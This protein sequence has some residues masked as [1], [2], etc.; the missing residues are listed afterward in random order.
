MSLF[1]NRNVIKHPLR[2][3]GC[4]NHGENAG[5]RLCGRRLMYLPEVANPEH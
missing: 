3:L 2:I 1:E 4:C 5:T